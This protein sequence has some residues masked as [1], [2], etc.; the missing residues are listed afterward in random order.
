VDTGIMDVAEPVGAE[1]RASRGLKLVTEN[2][3]FNGGGIA[4]GGIR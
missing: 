4:T 2:Y 1:H 3:M